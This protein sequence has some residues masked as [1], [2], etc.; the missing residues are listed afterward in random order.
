M[1]H[2]K[3]LI[4]ATLLTTPVAAQQFQLQLARDV[5]GQKPIHTLHAAVAGDLNGDGRVDL[6]FAGDAL[7]PNQPSLYLNNGQSFAATSWGLPA[8]NGGKRTL[9]DID[10]DGDLDVLQSFGALRLLQNDGTGAMTEVTVSQLPT[11]VFAFGRA[12]ASDIDGDGDTDVLGPRG[13]VLVNDGTGVFLDV[14]ATQLV[15]SGFSISQE[16]AVAD[17]DGDGDDDFVIMSGLHRNNGS[18]VFT[19]DP[20]ANLQHGYGELPFVLDADLDGDTDVLFSSG[21]YLQN[22]GAGVFTALANLLPTPLPGQPQVWSIAGFAD[23]NGDGACDVLLNPGSP[24][25]GDLPAW[26]LNDGQGSF[27]ITQQQQLPCANTSL[28]SPLAVDLDGDGDNDLVIGGAT[29]PGPALAEVLYNDGA[30]NFY[31]ATEHGGLGTLRDYGRIVADLDSD[32]DD[33]ILSGSILHR[34]DGKGALTLEYLPYGMRC[35]VVADFDGDGINDAFGGG[36]IWLAGGGGNFTAGPAL[37]SSNEHTSQAVATDLD[38]DADLDLLMIAGP[39]GLTPTL[40]LMRND[41]T[42]TFT[43]ISAASI[44]LVMPNP[45]RIAVGDCNG[46]G[47]QDLV[48]GFRGVFLF[49][50]S[51]VR[52]FAG[53]GAGL[54]AQLPM[55]HSQWSVRNVY[56]TDFEG[57]G[58]LDIVTDS[59][60]LPTLHIN[61]GTGQF[62]IQTLTAMAG[63]SLRPDDIDLDGDVDLWANGTGWPR[64]YVNDGSNT[65]THEATRVDPAQPPDLSPEFVL[66]D[67]DRDGDRD[68]VTVAENSYSQFQY[69]VPMWNHRRQLRAPNPCFAGGTLDLFISANAAHP[70]TP[71][72]FVGVSTT[73][74][75]V[76]MGNLGLLGIDLGTALLFPAIVSNGSTELSL[77]V[78][79]SHPLLGMVLHAQALLVTNGLHL[80]NT[81]TTTIVP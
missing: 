78:P 80:S 1:N 26:A 68:V 27:A 19:I 76:D 34:N 18:G 81:V 61:N 25:F 44:G 57:D 46:D 75:Q 16:M 28:I 77:A 7:T 42:G 62:A 13:L 64:V 9:L 50:G 63:Q 60:N 38:G 54:Y 32:G 4:Y 17:F 67:L 2:C 31:N 15:T 74:L 52:L 12:A 59:P 30:G 55:P 3:S 71:I 35:L 14:T 29:G 33:D 8:S 24:A 47:Q 40:R 21:R 6:L 10:G 43:A 22:N 56:V 45:T 39:W 53:N 48:F 65:F 11:N 79:N 69:F 36:S 20:A 73:A 23:L 5:L 41:G 66:I 70:A 58:D 72:A 49:G 37:I 51:P